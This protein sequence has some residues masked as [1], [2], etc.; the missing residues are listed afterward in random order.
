MGENEVGFC[1]PQVLPASPDRRPASAAVADKDGG[2]GKRVFRLRP[3]KRSPPDDGPWEGVCDDPGWLRL[4]AV[5]PRT[6]HVAVL[7]LK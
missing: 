3:R 7:K 1:K 2:N 5:G 4:V 6:L